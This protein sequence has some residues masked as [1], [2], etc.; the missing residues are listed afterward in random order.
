MMTQKFL[1]GFILIFT[2]NYSPQVF[3]ME[4]NTSSSEPSLRKM[5]QK[6]INLSQNEAISG[7]FK[8]TITKGQYIGGGVAAIIPGFG[9]GH[10]IQGRYREKG[11]MF[12][13]AELVTFGGA[14]GFSIWSVGKRVVEF[15]VK[16]VVVPLVGLG[17]EEAVE[18]FLATEIYEEK[19]WE[20]DVILAFLIAWLGVKIWQAVDI[21]YLP[22]HY[23]VITQNS[24]QAEPLIS[25]NSRN[26]GWDVGLT[27]KYNF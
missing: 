3:S 23:E 10:A 12:T 19:S 13:A 21:W 24:F 1:L 5:T 14:L 22:S 27:L 7:S 18:E 15:S 20:E 17:G 8:Q 6:K 2:A 25:W 4:N 16:M 9:I 11:W 26:S